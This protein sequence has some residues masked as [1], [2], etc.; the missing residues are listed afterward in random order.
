MRKA[1]IYTKEYVQ[2]V[3]IILLSLLSAIWLTITGR[4]NH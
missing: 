1:L 3:F 2:Y 4:R